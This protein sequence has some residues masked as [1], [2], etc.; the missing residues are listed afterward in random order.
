MTDPIQT[1]PGDARQGDTKKP[2]A[3]HNKADR[4]P[5]DAE[6]RRA[7]GAE[8]ARLPGEEGQ[9]LRSFLDVSFQA[10]AVEE[11]PSGAG[12]PSGTEEDLPVQ[13]GQAAQA[14]G[15]GP[16]AERMPAF[17]APPPKTGSPA[18][19]VG[20]EAPGGQE[21][22]GLAPRSLPSAAPLPGRDPGVSEPASGPLAASVRAAP[23]ALRAAG[24]QL[25]A[26]FVSL[27]QADG[28]FDVRIRTSLADGE[29]LPRIR[30]E[31]AAWLAAHGI[32][33]S[34]LRVERSDGFGEGSREDGKWIR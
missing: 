25:Q 32:R 5:F 29:E 17:P 30:D 1:R 9:T 7:L 19:Q 14:H 8:A 22:R 34:A 26:H 2:P 21:R 15:Q 10:V 12:H 33:I 18:L 28:G 31:V 11:A 23:R 4:R 3:E 16:V 6:L 13:A 24:G 20:T 27:L